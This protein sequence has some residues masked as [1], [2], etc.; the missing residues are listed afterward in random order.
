MSWS[1]IIRPNILGEP[2]LVQEST[3]PQ[4]IPTSKE[5]PRELA[6]DG[7]VHV[8]GHSETEAAL[9]P[10]LENLIPSN[11]VYFPNLLI[12]LLNEIST[13][14]IQLLTN[15]IRGHNCLHRVNGNGGEDG[16]SE[17]YTPHRTKGID[18]PTCESC[19]NLLDEGVKGI[20]RDTIMEDGH[21]KVLA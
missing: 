4:A 11:E 19:R 7:L 1:N 8:L 16:A 12:A 2:I 10:R 14:S 6:H 5:S 18:L 9:T 3:H 13:K 20:H 17:S 15:S 21:A